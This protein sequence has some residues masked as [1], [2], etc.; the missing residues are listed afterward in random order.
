MKKV[1]NQAP[2]VKVMCIKFLSFPLFLPNKSTSYVHNQALL[3]LTKSQ[4]YYALLNF[5]CKAL[6]YKN[7]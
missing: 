6:K 5:P 2:F 3:H 4:P 1:E 7:A